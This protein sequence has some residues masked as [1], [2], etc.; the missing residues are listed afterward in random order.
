M[1][2]IYEQKALQKHKWQSE[3]NRAFN[4]KRKKIIKTLN[5]LSYAFYI[6]FSLH[7]TI[8]KYRLLPFL[9]IQK[10]KYHRAMHEFSSLLFIWFANKLEPL[11]YRFQS[12]IT[13]KVTYLKGQN[14]CLLSQSLEIK[15]L[16]GNNYSV[17]HCAQTNDNFLEVIDLNPVDSALHYHPSSC[18]FF[19]PPAH[20]GS[21]YKIFL[22]PKSS[23]VL[24]FF[25]RSYCAQA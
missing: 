15:S 18:V 4:S 11:K 9:G 25:K 3:L 8:L 21:P 23:T 2:E 5:S 13:S 12:V 17:C 22:K 14:Y 10:D 7:R 20:V 16:L 1:S 6:Y 24:L 19:L